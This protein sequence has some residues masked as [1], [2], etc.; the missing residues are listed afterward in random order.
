VEGL[1]CQLEEERKGREDLA[2]RCTELQ[3]LVTVAQ[4]Q[5]S[6]NKMVCVAFLQFRKTLF[7]NIVRS[8][9]PDP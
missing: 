1:K 2:V 5:I 7:I 9:D 6:A 4:S 8:S 3:Q